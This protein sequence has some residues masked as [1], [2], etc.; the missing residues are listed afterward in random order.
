MAMSFNQKAIVGM[1]AAAAIVSLTVFS[2]WIRS[3]AMVVLYSGLAPEEASEVMDHLSRE[4]VKVELKQGGRT[5]LVPAS[6]VD[7]LRLEVSGQ[8][9]VTDGHFGWK[10]YFA[11]GSLGASQRELDVREKRALEGE[12]ARSI[13]TIEAVSHARV[14]INTPPTSLFL[15][16]RKGATASVVLSLRRR[17]APSR[18]QIEGIQN[19]VAS[20]VPGL[21]PGRVTVTDTASGRSLTAS[22]DGS[23]PARSNE[24]LRAQAEFEDYLT[25]KASAMLADILGP[26]RFVVRVGAQLDFEELERV[27][28]TY[29]P[30]TVVRSEG[31]AE[32]E[33]P[34]KSRGVTNYEINKTV[35]RIL[36]NGSTLK[37][38]SISVAVDGVYGEPA[39]DGTAPAYSPRSDEE[40]EQIRRVVAGAVGF[41]AGR[42]DT[43][44]VVNMRFDT[45]EVPTP[46]LVE[47]LE[48]LQ[49]LP[50]LV[51]R[52]LLF[53]V[54]AVVLL[55][56]RKSVAKILGE[57]SGPTARVAGRSRGGASRGTAAPAMEGEH[58][59]GVHAEVATLEDWARGNPDEVANLVQ[60]F[61]TQ[62]D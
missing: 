55:S 9:L 60:A 8:G 11:G 42:G 25:Q 59:H 15:R 22:S 30:N 5:I 50:S 52:F 49:D 31:V 43:I 3:D 45:P 14:H 61:A 10:D 44:E 39:E 32:S 41:D 13:E 2:L 51:G 19:L 48:W 57:A 38:L 24:Q 29:D 18:E 4:G 47:R 35:D 1:V 7:R 56:L 6:E 27:A 58:F 37:K 20:A 17:G 46:G 54:A 16:D 34:T 28:E 23:A 12:L 33:D 62:E 36:R 26:G 40:L 21:D 53:A